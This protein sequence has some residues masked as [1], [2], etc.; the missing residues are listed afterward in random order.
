MKDVGL[1]PLKVIDQPIDIRLIKILS[2]LMTH[3]LQR[4]ITPQSL[5]PWSVVYLTYPARFCALSE[6][7][8]TATQYNFN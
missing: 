8:N 2:K 5:R 7:Y 1:F 3:S 6:L 4:K